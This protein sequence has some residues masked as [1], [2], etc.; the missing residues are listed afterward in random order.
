M[1]LRITNLSK[2]IRSILIILGL[3]ICICI[4]ISNTSFSHADISYKTIYVSNGDTLWN[5]AKEEK[6]SNSYY[7][8]KDIRDI[9]N[10]IKSI[11][12]LNSSD[13]ATNQSLVIP[14]I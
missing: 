1:N 2:F 3:I 12:K 4:F 13:L 7:E 5:I 9:I 11:N 10:N 8:N 14:Y 6:E